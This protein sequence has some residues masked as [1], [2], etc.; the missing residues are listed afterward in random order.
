[1]GSCV[2]SDKPFLDSRMVRIPRVGGGVRG[3]QLA[4]GSNSA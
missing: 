3:S 4:N 1:M 2:F